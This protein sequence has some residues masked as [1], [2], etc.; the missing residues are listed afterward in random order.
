MVLKCRWSS[1][2]R[3][4]HFRLYTDPVKAVQTWT[5]NELEDDE[6]CKNS[7]TTFF[8]QQNKSKK[9]NKKNCITFPQLSGNNKLEGD[10]I[11]NFF[12]A[13]KKNYKNEFERFLFLCACANVLPASKTSAAKMLVYIQKNSCLPPLLGPWHSRPMSAVVMI[14]PFRIDEAQR[15]RLFSGHTNLIW[16]N[17]Q[18]NGKWYNNFIKSKCKFCLWG[19]SGQD[20]V[21][22]HWIWIAFIRNLVSKADHVQLWGFEYNIVDVPLL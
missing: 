10:E 18:M 7:A 11:C 13:K 15:W 12:P 1:C 19:V 17:K 3:P 22:I 6:I 21:Y 14:L 5:N 9:Q 16:S 4:W 8:F 20:P 2:T